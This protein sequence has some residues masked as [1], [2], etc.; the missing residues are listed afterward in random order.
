MYLLQTL[1][2][3]L[4]APAVSICDAAMLVIAVPMGSKDTMAPIVLPARTVCSAR[5]GERRL[6]KGIKSARQS[7]LVPGRQIQALSGPAHVAMKLNLLPLAET[8]QSGQRQRG[9]VPPTSSA[10]AADPRQHSMPFAKKRVQ[11]RALLF[12]F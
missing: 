5:S 2:M 3:V 9:K 1:N 10:R 11:S 12:S 8:Q 7:L 6:L 4:H